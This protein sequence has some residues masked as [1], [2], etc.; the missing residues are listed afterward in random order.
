MLPQTMMM[1]FLDPQSKLKH[2]VSLAQR[3]HESV[4]NTPDEKPVVGIFR[5]LV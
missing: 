2:S 1:I 4:G 3:F 5:R